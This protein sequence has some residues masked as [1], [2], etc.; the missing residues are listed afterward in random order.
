MV[1]NIALFLMAHA[2]GL[3]TSCFLPLS[4]KHGLRDSQIP[5]VQRACGSNLTA[6]MAENIQNPLIDQDMAIQPNRSRTEFDASGPTSI[7][8][9]KMQVY[10]PYAWAWP[11]DGPNMPGQFFSFSATTPVISVIKG[12]N[13]NE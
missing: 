11:P 1:N 8:V 2:V 12:V 10:K 7:D 9:P 5:Q 6:M 3:L 4:G 13:T